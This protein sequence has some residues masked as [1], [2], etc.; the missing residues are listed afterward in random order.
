MT[1]LR[2]QRCSGS[3]FAIDEYNHGALT[4]YASKE[5]YEAFKAGVDA[6]R[7][8]QVTSREIEMTMEAVSPIHVE[9]G[10]D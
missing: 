1:D 10:I 9:V 5:V 6:Y 7:K 8:D 2:E 3:W 4:T